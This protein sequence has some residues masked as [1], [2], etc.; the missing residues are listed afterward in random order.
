[1]ACDGG[2]DTEPD[3]NPLGRRERRR[4]AGESTREEAVLREP[5]LAEAGLGSTRNP[6][7]PLG[8]HVAAEDDPDGRAVSHLALPELR[9]CD[10]RRTIF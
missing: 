9:S 1:V 10:D 4:N 7:D 5:E 6:N 8:R 2:G 3:R